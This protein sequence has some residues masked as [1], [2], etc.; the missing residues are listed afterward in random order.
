MGKFE[1]DD[2]SYM[3]LIFMLNA[4]TFLQGE[5]YF[6]RLKRLWKS[7]NKCFFEENI[8]LTEIRCY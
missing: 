7:Q 4:E 8:L 2:K 6:F 1:M 3:T 5:L